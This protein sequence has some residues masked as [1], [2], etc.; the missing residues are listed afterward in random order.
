MK[1]IVL[2]FYYYIITKEGDKMSVN[3][4]ST[5]TPATSSYNTTAA[6]ADNKADT[7]AKENTYGKDAAA[8]YESSST[9]KTSVTKKSNP[10]LVAKLKA[11]SEQRVSQ[12]KSLVEKM[13]T[14]QGNAVKK[15]D[16]MWKMLASGNF[17]VDSATAAQAKAD[18]AEDG[19]WG[20]TQTSDRIFDFAM[21][22]S[23]GDDKKMDEML[24]AFEKGFKAATKSWG[25]KLPD[26]SQ[27][28]YDA[29][30]EKF[31]EYKESLQTEA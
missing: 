10:E 19:Y 11:D 31:K 3:G 5:N 22:L 24:A 4:V 6:K 20:V 30:H 14:N 27:R 15:A 16:D 26:I 13:F 25:S 8:V 1:P 2:R 21:A 18:I 7:T 29:V 12:L 17:T 23:G 28:T 9:K